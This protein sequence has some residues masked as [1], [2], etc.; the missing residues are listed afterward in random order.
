MKKIWLPVTLVTLIAVVSLSGCGRAPEVPSETSHAST[1][2]VVFELIVAHINDTHS[3][4]DPV[5]ASF[6]AEE[7]TVF[8]EFGGHP[9]ILEQANAYRAQAQAENTAMLFLHG[10][11]AWQGSAYF[12]INEGRMNA[13]ILS[14]MNLDAMALGNH[15]FDL[16]NALLNEF[17]DTINFPVLAAN[18]DASLDPDLKDQSNLRPYVLFAFDGY[19]KIQLHEFADLQDLDE[20]YHVVGV[21]GLALEDMPNISPDTGQVQ[22]FSVVESAQAMVDEFADHGV[23]NVIAVTHLG[24]AVDVHVAENVN[25]IDAIVGGHSHSLLGDFT[26][27]GLGYAG[28]YAQ[29]VVNPNQLDATC[30]VQAGEYAQAIGNVRLKFDALGQLQ[31]CNGHNILLSN[32]EFYQSSARSNDVRL[33]G[34]QHSQVLDFIHR[35][36][37][38]TVA[39]E[40]LELRAHIDEVY[41]PHVEQA[42]GQVIGMLPAPLQHVRRPG[43]G[44]SNQHG[45]QVAPL[46]AL[47]QYEWVN[48]AWVQ[49]ITGVSPDF[50]LVG[51]GGIRQSL[52]EGELR[53][54]DISLELLPFAN[55]LAIVPLTGSQVLDLLHEAIVATL[56]EGAHA[57]KFPYGGN[58]RYTFVETAA[59]QDGEVTQAEVNRGTWFTPDWQPLDQAATYQVVMNSYNATGNDGW[60][61]L[62]QAQSEISGRIDLA[63]VHGELQVFPVQ[64]ITRTD[65]RLQVQ[66]AEDVLSCSAEFVSCNTDAL[67]VIEFI[68]DVYVP[69]LGAVMPVKYPMVTL[70]LME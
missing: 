55:F 44:D 36:P 66:Y 65:G 33:S 16:T 14:R 1:P 38:I 4:F 60:T 23:F 22:F 9:R 61:T 12:K 59:G 58:F 64:R 69:A 7:L 53:E 31:Y 39:A 13:D 25:G 37:K 63:Y 11:D 56:P 45:S 34:Q 15:E 10:G 18:I 3:A 62:Y 67:A 41:K 70:K 57:G 19:E 27:L 35:H 8:N 2:D 6:R 28:D 32:D 42:Y 49:E 47:A 17:L 29:W 43:D 26:E 46:V 52:A 24:H 50:A 40:H 51:A 54:G 21:F 20:R 48:Q 5:P 68:R 30:I